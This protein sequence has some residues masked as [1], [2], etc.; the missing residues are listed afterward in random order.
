MTYVMGKWDMLYD[1]QRLLRGGFLEAVM[2]VWSPDRS[3]SNNWYRESRR[4]R[5]LRNMERLS[6]VLDTVSLRYP[7]AIGEEMS[8]KQL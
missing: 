3:C 7:L 1:P 2:S 5:R 6:S 8:I 4:R